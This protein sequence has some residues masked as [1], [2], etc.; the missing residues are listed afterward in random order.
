M[1]K[2]S[3]S[4]KK[5]ASMVKNSGH[6]HEVLFNNIFG[7]PD[8]NLSYTKNKPDCLITSAYHKDELKSLSPTGHDVS[9]KAGNTW[10]I[11]LGEIQ[12]LTDFAV[13]NKT[14]ERRAP[15]PG[16]RPITRGG[17]GVSWDSQKIALQ[18]KGFWAK[19][20]RKGDLLCYYDKA[21]NWTFFNMDQVISFII[22]F[23]T[24]RMIQASGRI[25]GDFFNTSGVLLQGI[26]TYEYRSESHKRTFV[27][28][29]HGGVGEGANG[30]R[31]FK[32]LREKI[33]SSTFSTKTQ[34]YI[35]SHP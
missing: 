8:A 18:S 32:L 12:E 4:M 6:K 23:G 19:Y 24:W 22:E 16:L 30:L 13:W 29:A 27:L 7:N 2:R 35:H 9:L 15:A 17:H 20:F 11:H 1:S 14:L 28:G 3:E 34:T 33:P 10:Q 25:K 5:I 26:I 31:L 21:C